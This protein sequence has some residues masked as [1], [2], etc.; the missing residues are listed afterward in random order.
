MPDRIEPIAKE[1]VRLLDAGLE[2]QT[3]LAELSRPF[4]DVT[5]C[6]RHRLSFERR[7]GQKPP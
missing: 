3:L 4:P 2:G 1:I 6:R 5:R 7:I